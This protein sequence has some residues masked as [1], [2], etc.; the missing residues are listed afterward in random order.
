MA[1]SHNVSD[2]VIEPIFSRQLVYNTNT[3]CNILLPENYG[4]TNLDKEGGSYGL[5]SC[6]EVANSI[7]Q[8][9]SKFNGGSC[10]N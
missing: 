3:F 2:S 10:C 1:Y 9:R 6:L 7:A 5:L 4:P 8:D